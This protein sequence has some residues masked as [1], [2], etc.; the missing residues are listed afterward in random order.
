[1]PHLAFDV[2]GTLIDHHGTYEWF[3]RRGIAQAREL[4]TQWREKQLE[5][6]FRRALMRTYADFPTCTR[7]AL[8]FV[9]ARHGIVLTAADL[10]ELLA[11]YRQLPAYPDVAAGLTELQRQGVP[12]WAFSNGRGDDVQALLDQAG[13]A[14]LITGVVSLLDI[15]TYKPDPAAYA[16][17]RQRAATGEDPVWLISSNPFDLI[18]GKATGMRTIWVRRQATAL[19]DP[20][21]ERPDAEVRDIGGISAVLDAM[22]G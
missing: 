19:F 2:Y 14:P 8:L 17:F 9:C 6:T 22:S 20:W 15:R 11:L 5:Y 1:M 7:E 4:L 10:D 21:G 16:Y 13:L 3:A 12:C 18:G